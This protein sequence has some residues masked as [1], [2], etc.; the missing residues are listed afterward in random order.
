MSNAYIYDEL[1]QHLAIVMLLID[2]ISQSPALYQ[3][4]PFPELLIPTS[5]ELYYLA[6]LFLRLASSGTYQR[7]QSSDSFHFPLVHEQL[8]IFSVEFDHAC[9]ELKISDYPTII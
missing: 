5:S 8:P 9:P 7:H 6:I 1:V 2:G 3:V 4:A